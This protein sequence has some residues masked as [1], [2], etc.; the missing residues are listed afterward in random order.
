MR[1]CHSRMSL[2]FEFDYDLIDQD[3]EA[4]EK[5]LR[6]LGSSGVVHGTRIAVHHH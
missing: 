5:K 1:G 3:V 2:A 4:A 6:Q